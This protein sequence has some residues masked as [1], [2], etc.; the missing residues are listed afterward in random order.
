VPEG[1]IDPPT[2]HM[3]YP[4]SISLTAATYKALLI[5][6]LASM[7]A[8]GFEHVVLIGDSGGNQAGMQE[9]AA[10]LSRTWA[11]SKTRV[12]FIP[13][14]YDYPA[15]QKWVKSQGIDEVDE[16]FHDEYSISTM[17]MAVD[18]ASVRLAQRAA[19]NKASINGVSLLP[20]EKA[21]AFGKRAIEWRAALTVAAIKKAISQ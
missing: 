2:S 18:P 8:H 6:V 5:D 19:K 9:V 21:I 1:D 10:E 15:L 11:G 20:Q 3:R 7:K 17:M 12:H 14:Y 4:G 16:G 13:E